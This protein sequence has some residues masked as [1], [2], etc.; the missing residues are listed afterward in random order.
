MY[1]DNK[2]LSTV[3]PCVPK[4]AHPVGVL[5]LPDS[6]IWASPDIVS[7]ETQDESTLKRFSSFHGV[8]GF[9]RGGFLLR[10]KPPG[11]TGFDL[12]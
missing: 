1:Q 5:R 8:S 3:P 11:G 9:V 12:R 2:P 10:K 7:E 6:R 4:V